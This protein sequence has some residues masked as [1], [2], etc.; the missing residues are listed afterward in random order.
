MIR[1]ICG[2]IFV[3]ASRVKNIFLIGFIILFDLIA[4]P[5]RT[6]RYDGVGNTVVDDRTAPNASQSLSYNSSN[7][8]V[9][10]HGSKGSGIYI[11]SDGGTRVQKRAS[12]ISAN[13]QPLNDSQLLNSG[14]YLTLEKKN[15]ANGVSFGLANHI[16]L[17]GVR[18]ASV[19]PGARHDDAYSEI[20]YY[21]VD[22]VSSVKVTLDG[23]GNVLARHEYLP[24]GDELSLS[25]HS[26][27]EGGG[28]KFNAQEKDEESG[29]D[30]FNA[31]HYDSE[32]AHFVSADTVI[33]GE[34]SPMGW[35]RY[36]YVGGN[37]VKYSDPTGN[38]LTA[39]GDNGEQIGNLNN[40]VTSLESRSVTADRT[41]RSLRTSPVDWRLRFHNASTTFDFEREALNGNIVRG[42]IS[43]D[44][45]G[46]RA[47]QELALFHGMHSASSAY[48]E[49]PANFDA[50]NA[51]AATR[52]DISFQSAIIITSVAITAATYRDLSLTSV[53]TGLLG[54][55]TIGGLVPY[56][57]LSTP[58]RA[59]QRHW[60]VWR[61]TQRVRN[62]TR[63]WDRAAGNALTQHIG[64]DP[65]DL[66]FSYLGTSNVTDRNISY[67]DVDGVRPP[68]GGW[69]ADRRAAKWRRKKQNRAARRAAEL[70]APASA[71]P[72]PP[73]SSS[74]MTM[75]EMRAARMA[76]FSKK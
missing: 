13:G 14:L 51:E 42:T 23:R 7:C 8:I 60:N 63:E 70:P 50:I 5:G 57:L 53:A 12:I 62:E 58:W 67:G 10:A 9:V 49:A 30:F 73:A 33:N 75:A 74:T 28:A 15:N 45:R 32:I 76:Y 61:D 16:Y 21:V 48:A 4:A 19:A 40:M 59:I 36:M 37:P 20:R 31:R 38:V 27:G 6:L 66:V 56:G 68:R 2:M 46:D 25:P 44:Q 43:I 39:E 55:A 65:F 52:V 34:D 18:I 47:T 41:I 29:L 17:N 3:V 11:F 54:G 1:H 35:N 64:G 71:A 69:P 26:G 22:Q 72:A 24:Y